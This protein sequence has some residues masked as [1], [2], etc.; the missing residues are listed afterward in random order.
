MNKYPTSLKDE[1]VQKYIDGQSL[2]RLAV[3]Y[4]IN[5]STIKNWLYRRGVSNNGTSRFY[6]K[7]EIVDDH[8]EMWVR[9]KDDFVK[10][11]IDIEDVDRCKERGV[12]SRCGN[13]YIVHAMSGTYLH[14]FIMNCPAGL[15]VDHIH[16]NILDNR[17]DQLRVVT[18]SQQ[19]MNTKIR[20]NNTSGYRGVYY[21]KERDTWNVHICIDGK[22]TCKRF[23][24]K[25]DAIRFSRDT[26]EASRAEYLYQG[27]EAVG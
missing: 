15:E 3:E 26:Y 7:Y 9:F 14:R 1:I 4:D 27:G 23:K 6:Q 25:E 11:L 10:V 21:D 13:G 17:R 8:A 22:R 24:S 16:H 20:R 5:Y 19:K 18:S 2:N 12:W